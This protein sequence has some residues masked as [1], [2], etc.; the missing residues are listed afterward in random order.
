MSVSTR[1][2]PARHVR[3]YQQIVEKSSL[4]FEDYCSPLSFN[5]SLKLLTQ[6]C[7]GFQTIA[8]VLLLFGHRIS[9]E[10]M[11]NGNE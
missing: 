10:A 5:S 8:L 7:L 4:P 11:N 6:V 3:T 2:N 1:E 9:Y